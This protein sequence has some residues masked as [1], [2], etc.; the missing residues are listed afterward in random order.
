VTSKIK[1]IDFDDF[2]QKSPLGLKNRPPT[3]SGPEFLV[4]K[5]AKKVDFS[6]FKNFKKK[7]KSDLSPKIESKKMT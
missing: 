2:F 5:K 6:T 3:Q 4:S 1:K 7:F